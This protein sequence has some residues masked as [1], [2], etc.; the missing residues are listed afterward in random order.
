MLFLNCN[1][2][3]QCWSSRLVPH[4]YLIPPP[5]P[6]FMSLKQKLMAKVEGIL[7]Y[8]LQ[9]VFLFTWKASAVQFSDGFP[10]ENK[11]P[12]SFSL[13]LLW[14]PW[15]R[16]LG[17]HTLPHSAV[18]FVVTWFYPFYSWQNTWLPTCSLCCLHLLVDN[19]HFLVHLP[20]KRFTLV[21][22]LFPKMQTR[23]SLKF[24]LN[25]WYIPSQ[26]SDFPEFLH[27]TRDIPFE[28]L[29]RAP[30]SGHVK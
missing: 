29:V 25:M 23:K 19:T 28:R 12:V 5:L 18:V 11:S 2:Q 17:R 22:S 6:L 26:D 7:F 1:T 24:L 9:N 27:C 14:L 8:I 4:L 21:F 30:P 10:K 15:P 3:G 16:W 13:K 20:A